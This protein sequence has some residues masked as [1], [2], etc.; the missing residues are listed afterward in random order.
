MKRK[1]GRDVGILVALG[2]VRLPMRKRA[3]T[4]RAL[5]FLLDAQT[6][7]LTRERD[8]YTEISFLLRAFLLAMNTLLF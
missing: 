4:P 5:H 6:H 7:S 1:V 2:Q 8:R 3:F